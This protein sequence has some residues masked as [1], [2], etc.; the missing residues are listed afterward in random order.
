MRIKRAELTNWSRFRGTHRADF[1]PGVHA[2]TAKH[3]DNAERSNWL[4]KSSFMWA[5]SVFALYGIKMPSHK[6]KDDWI[7]DGEA[8]GCVAVDYTNGL[9]IKRTRE[10]GSSDKLRVTW[11]G[12]TSNGKRAQEVIESVVRMSSDDFMSAF[13]FEQKMMSALILAGS[14]KLHEKARAWFELVK[15]QDAFEHAKDE[16]KGLQK[17][18]TDLTSQLGS[19]VVV[20]ENTNV[21]ELEAAHSEALEAAHRAQAEL[22]WIVRADGA[23]EYE[24]VVERAKALK[25]QI[26][27][28]QPKRLKARR[29]ALVDAAT[30]AAVERTKAKDEYY[31]RKKLAGG[32]FDGSCPVMCEECP[33]TSTVNDL[34]K[35]NNT[36][37]SRA[38]KKYEAA[39]KASDEETARVD[40]ID[41][42]IS[43]F[44]RLKR[45]FK[46]LEE[47]ARAKR[48]DAEFI[49]EHGEPEDD[50]E[51]LRVACQEAWSNEGAARA[52]LE[53]AKRAVKAIAEEEASKKKLETEVEAIRK[54]IGLRTKAMAVFKRAQRAIAETAIADIEKDANALLSEA[55]IDLGIAVTWERPI[56]GLASHCDQCGHSYGTSQRAKE[57]PDC[58][59]SRPQKRK[60][61]LDITPSDR[62]GAADDLGGISFQL[63][64]ASWLRRK[65]QSPWSVALIDEPFSACDPHNKVAL[66]TQL[67]ALLNSR[68]GFEQAFITAHDRSVL[69]ALPERFEITA[70]SGGSSFG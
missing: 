40:A 46:S 47:K 20:T 14:S 18:E 64:V 19:K 36:L 32:N 42:E 34:L 65:R 23:R 62:S 57:C 12:T 41:E 54:Q 44:K 70:S 56:Q 50:D 45:E 5:V 15:L 10:R 24:Q 29:E 38:R 11:Q 2:V 17:N 6:Y 28:M 35:S 48:S 22:D 8:S 59:S 58:G 26:T 16:R 1:G 60:E 67:N 21:D 4:G 43:A 30:N 55:G 69:D 66:A 13:F 37:T 27:S 52:E 25:K 9:S 3:V 61:E 53:A 33:A 63:G 39:Q 31:E 68:F 51:A 7:T 49:A